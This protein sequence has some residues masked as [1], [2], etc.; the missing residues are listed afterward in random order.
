MIGEPT[1][2]KQPIPLWKRAILWVAGLLAVALLVFVAVHVMI[3]PV[4]PDQETPA[5]HFGRPCVLCH[6]VT[7][8]TDVV[9]PGN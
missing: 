2:S 3:Q 1:D 5:G 7:E 8:G 9:N 6:I 4:S